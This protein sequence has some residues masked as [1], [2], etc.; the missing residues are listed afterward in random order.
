[1][2][3]PLLLDLT[4]QLYLPVYLPGANLSVGDLHF[5]QG[6]GELSVRPPASPEPTYPPLFVRRRQ[7]DR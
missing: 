1:M 7:A 2:D 3:G 6:D 4:T 5:S